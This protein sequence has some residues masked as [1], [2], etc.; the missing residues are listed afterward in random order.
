MVDQQNVHASA[1]VA[2]ISWTG[3]KDCNL[4]LLRAWRNGD[5]DVRY[6]VVFRISTKPFQAHPIPFMEAQARSLGLKLIFI[7]FPDEVDDWMEAYVAGISKVRDEYDI[8]VIV[9]GDINLVGTMQR[10]WMDRACEG[11]G[12]KCHLPLWDIDK[13]KTLNL[14]LDEGFEIIFS[15]V[16]APFFDET[17]IN[18]RLDETSLAEMKNI[19][20]K[21]LTEE[22]IESGLKP[23][24]LCGERGEY[25][26]M[27]ISGPLYKHKVE[28]KINPQPM[29][30]EIEQTKWK[31]N[32]HNSN[33][34]WAIS[35][36]ID[37]N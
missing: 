15:C 7:D 2:A 35:L 36:N 17:W 34:I 3:G 30:Q 8:Q 37:A 14:M 5:F 26:T 12:I 31:G 1:A 24:D 27:C 4:A 22:Q 16:K 19:I 21:G 18:R 13:E 25:H 29:K 6:L 32:I 10:N 9:T 28:M 23:L 11:A 20:F 33:C